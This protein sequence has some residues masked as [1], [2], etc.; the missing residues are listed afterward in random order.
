ME[1]HELNYGARHRQHLGGSPS[2]VEGDGCWRMRPRMPCRVVDSQAEAIDQRE[3]K[4]ILEAVLVRVVRT[5][6]GRSADVYL[7]KDLK[8]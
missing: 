1:E 4:A 5:G 2:A 6:P 3:L 7:G 8:S